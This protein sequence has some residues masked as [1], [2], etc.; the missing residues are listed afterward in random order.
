[1]ESSGNP[2]P[3]LDALLSNDAEMVLLADDLQVVP[4]QMGKLTH[5]SPSPEAE[6]GGDCGNWHELPSILE[7]IENRYPLRSSGYHRLCSGKPSIQ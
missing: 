1:M 3:L 7:I 2:C 4:S 5:P 6:L